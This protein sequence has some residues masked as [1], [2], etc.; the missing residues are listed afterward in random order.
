MSCATAA[1]TGICTVNTTAVTTNS[2]IFLSERSDTTMGTTL[3]VTCN[4]TVDTV[5]RKI[6]AV[7]AATSFTFNVGVIT[8]NP[9]C[10]DYQ[11]I[12]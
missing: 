1:S 6:T 9:E 4:T 8:S 2:E 11:I 7:V 3:G 12:N 5:S 10:W